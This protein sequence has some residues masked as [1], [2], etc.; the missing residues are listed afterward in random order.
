[1]IETGHFWWAIRHV[2]RAKQQRGGAWFTRVWANDTAEFKTLDMSQQN[3]VAGSNNVVA[4]F[5]T[6]L[7]K[8]WCDRSWRLARHGERTNEWAGITNKSVTTPL[9]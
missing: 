6:L 7:R 9:S 5:P 3:I 2:V 4:P 8:S 1:M